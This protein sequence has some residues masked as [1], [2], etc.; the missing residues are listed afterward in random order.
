M[1]RLCRLFSFAVYGPACSVLLLALNL[2]PE[3]D[4]MQ[5]ALFNFHDRALELKPGSLLQLCAFCL[6]QNLMAGPVWD[7]DPPGV[8]EVSTFGLSTLLF[9]PQL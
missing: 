1:S 4:K 7:Y 6:A 2:Y 5:H 9:R 3:R 8:Q